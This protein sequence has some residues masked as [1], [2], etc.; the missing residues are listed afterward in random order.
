LKTEPEPATY[1]DLAGI[2]SGV[3]PETGQLLL[4][5]DAEDAALAQGDLKR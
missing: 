5:A 3:C 1:F 2:V 4:S